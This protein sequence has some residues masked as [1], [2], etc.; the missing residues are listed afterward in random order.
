[1]EMMTI[2]AALIMS[3][4]M[5]AAQN[6]E[7][8][9]CY[10]ADIENNHV[11]SQYVYDRAQNQNPT[12]KAVILT[13]KKKYDYTYDEDDRL[14]ARTTSRWDGKEWQPTDRLEYEYSPVGYSIAL[15]RWDAECQ[16]FT[17][18][19][20]KTV[21]TETT[22]FDVVEGQTVALTDVRSNPTL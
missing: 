11:V 10:N 18:P 17:E 21:Y 15:S 9:F 2:T 1:M 22:V 20:A 14:L 16:N 4:Y 7:S 6:T 8:E 19:L 3:T 13:P 5:N 12:S